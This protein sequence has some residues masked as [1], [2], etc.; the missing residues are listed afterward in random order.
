M[1]RE[2][3][4]LNMKN[5]KVSWQKAAEDKEIVLGI[6][7]KAES[8][9]TSWERLVEGAYLE[10]KLQKLWED[11]SHELLGLEL[12]VTLLHHGTL[13]MYSSGDLSQRLSFLTKQ[14]DELSR[15]RVENAEFIRSRLKIQTEEVEKI[16]VD[17]A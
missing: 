3:E 13:G 14:R 6:Q 7:A 9:K 5:N 16:L 12:Q 4:E 17:V 10:G 2:S 15:L 8:D 11:Y 1:V